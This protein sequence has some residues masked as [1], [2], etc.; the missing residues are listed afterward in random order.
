MA[1]RRLAPRRGRVPLRGVLQGTV[2][3]A[4]GLRGLLSPSGLL[5]TR[6]HRWGCL[7]QERSP[8]VECWA[9]PAGHK[10]H[11]HRAL[12]SGG[13][14]LQGRGLHHD[15]G[16]PSAVTGPGLT[17]SIKIHELTR[18]RTSLILVRVP[19]LAVLIL[20]VLS[21][22]ASVPV[23]WGRK[24]AA[25]A[26]QL[27]V[28][29]G[30]LVRVDASQE[31]FPCQHTRRNHHIPLPPVRQSDGHDSPRLAP[32]RDHHRDIQVVLAPVASLQRCCHLRPLSLARLAHRGAAPPHSQG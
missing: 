14:A 28:L 12:V 29:D 24:S 23:I 10:P 20:A 25:A 26:N 21:E 6:L 4:L 13:G 22:G 7:I 3:V 2:R 32:L 9:S 27:A 15:L 1:L 11:A 17:V 18:R 19:L 8:I 5:E 30:R 16:G 31:G